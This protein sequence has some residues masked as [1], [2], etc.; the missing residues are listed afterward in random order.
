VTVKY[1]ATSSAEQSA[2]DATSIATYGQQGYIVTTTLHN[3]AD[4]L[5]QAEFYLEL[6]A[7]P[8][9]IFRTLNYELTNSELTD[10][11]RDDL[12]GIFMG[13]P[14]NITDLP[15][16]MISGAFQGFVEG[17][18][19]SSSYNRLALTVNLSPVAYS[20]Q[21]MKWLNVP[22]VETWQTISPTL[23]W[24]NATIVA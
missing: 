22:I 4:A 6:R 24:E 20:L 21:A 10:I 7:Y 19:F 23:T 14:V 16:N 8:Q 18:T 13:L 2:S 11:D 5:S 3:S 12:L 9:D 17:W 15:A 1:N